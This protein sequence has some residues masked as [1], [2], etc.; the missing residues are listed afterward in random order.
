MVT[1]INVSGCPVPLLRS[2][3]LRHTGFV[4]WRNFYLVLTLT[5]ASC[6]RQS[7][8]TG[9]N[10]GTYMMHLDRMRRL[11]PRPLY[12]DLMDIVNGM[13]PVSFCLV[14]LTF[15]VVWM[16]AQKNRNFQHSPPFSFCV[17]LFSQI[18][19]N[20]LSTLILDVD[21]SYGTGKSAKLRTFQLTLMFGIRVWLI[22][23]S[24]TKLA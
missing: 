5:Y 3:H 15:F 23:S 6:V 13:Y 22:R 2:L 7:G 19:E 1:T 17:L 11:Q 10:S 21:A 16:T 20:S 18:R 14:V 4:C 9:L 24:L 12:D 8:L